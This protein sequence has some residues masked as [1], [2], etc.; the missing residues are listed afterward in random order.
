MH[1][2]FTRI[3]RHAGA[4]VDN[5]QIDRAFRPACDREVYRS[6]RG[7]VFDRIVEQVG[8]RLP[9][10]VPVAQHHEVFCDLA[11]EA[12]FGFV[13]GRLEQFGEFLCQFGHI[14]PHTFAFGTCLQPGEAQDGVEC[15]QHTVHFLDRFAQR[16]LGTFA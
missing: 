12:L 2:A 11:A 6:P 1:N 15:S 16:C 5:R 9:D 4:R 7:R 14:H 10:Q 8:E 13:A 3:R